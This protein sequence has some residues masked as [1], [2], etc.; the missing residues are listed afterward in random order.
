MKNDRDGTFRLDIPA[1]YPLRH[2]N[3]PPRESDRWDC[4]KHFAA[5]DFGAVDR[6][7]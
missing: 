1:K 7:A 2:G 5:N 3:G 6:K 4:R